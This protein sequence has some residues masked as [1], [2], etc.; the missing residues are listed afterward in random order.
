ML[1]FLSD[2]G[3]TS[4]EAADRVYELV[5]ETPANYLKYYVGYLEFL[6]L[7]KDARLCYGSDYND[8]S[9]HQALLSIG[10]APFSIIKKYFPLYYQASSDSSDSNA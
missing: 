7:K 8:K 2:Y 5:V 9:F 6:E 1:E 4:V 3:I 10:P